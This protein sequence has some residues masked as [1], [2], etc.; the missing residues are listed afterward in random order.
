MINTTNAA[1]LSQHAFLKGNGCV[2]RTRSY[3]REAKTIEKIVSTELKIM[4]F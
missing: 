3:G 2:F 1:A 4:T